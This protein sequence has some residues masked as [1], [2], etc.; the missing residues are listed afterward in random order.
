MALE[1]VGG[2]G[3]K[4]AA[5]RAPV[6]ATLAEAERLVSGVRVRLQGVADA[7]ADLRRRLAAGEGVGEPHARAGGGSG[8]GAPRGAA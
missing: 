2:G 3:Q 6:A 8:T 7:L 1:L 4:D 5:E